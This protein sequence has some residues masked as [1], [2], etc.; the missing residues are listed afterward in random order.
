MGGGG[1]G[2][3][4]ISRINRQRYVFI[5]WC[6]NSVTVHLTACGEAAAAAAEEEEEEARGHVVH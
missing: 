4:Q 5:A 1:A 6:A 3:E 2:W